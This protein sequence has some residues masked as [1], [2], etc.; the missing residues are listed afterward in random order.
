MKNRLKDKKMSFSKPID[1]QTDLEEFLTGSVK[2][3]I[4]P[5]SN[6]RKFN[7]TA[8]EEQIQ[9]LDKKA[10]EVDRSRNYIVAKLINAFYKGDIDIT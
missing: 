5:T 6:K 2:K 10:K 8:P 7:V 9:F 4:K 3:Q 1:E